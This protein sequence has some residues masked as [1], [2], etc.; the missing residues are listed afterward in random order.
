MKKLL[1]L[2]EKKSLL[3]FTQRWQYAFDFFKLN[4]SFPASYSHG[5]QVSLR[6]SELRK[7]REH[8]CLLNEIA[9][10]LGVFSKPL[11]F[12]SLDI[13]NF[14]THSLKQVIH[15]ARFTFSLQI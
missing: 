6:L 14:V 1:W 2:D 9:G 10:L 3:G 4:S 13:L 15:E 8:P 11:F 5:V 12:L 7:L